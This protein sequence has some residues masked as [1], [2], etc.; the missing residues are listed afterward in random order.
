MS[1]IQL[2]G[3]LLGVKFSLMGEDFVGPLRNG[4]RKYRE[5]VGAAAID[6]GTENYNS[7][8]QVNGS[9]LDDLHRR[10]H[11]F[12]FGHIMLNHNSNSDV[13]KVIVGYA[14]QGA[15]QQPFLIFPIDV[16]QY[17]NI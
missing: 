5:I 1:H 17:V 7:Q 2:R 14:H 11:S 3:T 9:S 16:A 6:R 12:Q 10:Q 13:F 8:G 4:I 15:C